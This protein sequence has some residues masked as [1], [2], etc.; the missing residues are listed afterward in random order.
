MY[1]CNLLNSYFFY[2]GAVEVVNQ[3]NKIGKKVLFVT[4]NSTKTRKQYLEKLTSLGFKATETDIFG[5][6]Y[7]SALYLKNEKKVGAIICM[8]CFVSEND[9]FMYFL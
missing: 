6:A 3:L 5:T 4:N 7:T 8:V 2:L 1:V 9:K